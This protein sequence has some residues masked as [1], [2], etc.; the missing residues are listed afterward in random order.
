L[1][2]V[3]RLMDPRSFSSTISPFVSEVACVVVMAP[4]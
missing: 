1:S 2:A 3:T 4:R